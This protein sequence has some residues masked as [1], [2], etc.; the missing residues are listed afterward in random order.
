MDASRKVPPARRTVL[1]GGAATLVGG[2]LML[3]G[4]Q[5]SQ[6]YWP[7]FTVGASGDHVFALQDFLNQRSYWCGTPDGYFGGLTQQ[8]VWALQKASGLTPDAIVGRN[9]LKAISNWTQPVLH[10]QGPGTRVAVDLATQLL[11]VTRDG[12]LQLTLNTSTGN[13]EPYDWYGRE[14]NATTPP[15]VFEVFSTYSAGWQTGP[16]GDLYR[17]QYFNGGIAVHGSDFIPPYPDSHGCCRVSVAAMDMLWEG[18][19]TTGT[20]VVVV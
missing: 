20:P 6:A 7:T 11:T 5:S 18:V 9:T 12:V 15:G 3:L 4:A 2:G 13:G 8:A 14:L 19:M 1:R 17:P 16:L 10:D